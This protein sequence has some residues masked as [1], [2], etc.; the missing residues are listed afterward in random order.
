MTQTRKN[1]H[2]CFELVFPG[3]GVEGGSLSVL[4]MNGD[5]ASPCR[6][7]EARTC[8]CVSCV[9]SCCLLFRHE[10]RSPAGFL[11]A[12]FIVGFLPDTVILSGIEALIHYLKDRETGL[13]A[14]SSRANILSQLVSWLGRSNVGKFPFVLLFIT[15]WIV[16]SDCLLWLPTP[17]HVLP[18]GASRASLDTE[19]F[20][21]CLFVKWPLAGDEPDGEVWSGASPWLPG[22]PGVCGEMSD[23]AS[24][25]GIRWT[26]GGG[27]VSSSPPPA[28]LLFH[29]IYTETV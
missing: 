25:W 28:N 17:V 22:S 14:G 21:S 16:W 29:F 2:N 1:E 6:L 5:W 24:V 15:P 27:G 11:Q 7:P 20:S 26:E 23:V 4:G 18:Q 8:D 3:V 10:G 9:E 13:A 12:I 19:G